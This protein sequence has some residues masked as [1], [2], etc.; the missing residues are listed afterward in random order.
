MSL[1][2]SK[3]DLKEI[4]RDG[5]WIE[6]AQDRDQWWAR[7]GIRGIELLGSASRKLVNL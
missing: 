6:L 7:F 3:I 5:N 4:I 1:L 2:I